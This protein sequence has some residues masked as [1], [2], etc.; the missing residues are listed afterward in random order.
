M[1]ENKGAFDQFVGEYVDDDEQHNGH[2]AE[3][4]EHV[5]QNHHHLFA[6]S[7]LDGGDTDVL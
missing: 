7:Q 6:E 2:H 4:Q 5:G 1:E 3:N